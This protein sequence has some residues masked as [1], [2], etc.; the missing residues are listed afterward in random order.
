M[1]MMVALEQDEMRSS[2]TATA[3]ASR[4]PAIKG[5][6]KTTA[7]TESPTTTKT[8][9]GVTMNDLSTAASPDT[10]RRGMLKKQLSFE[11]DDPRQGPPPSTPETQRPRPQRPDPA[12]ASATS[13]SV[14]GVDPDVQDSAAVRSSR[15]K[16][17]AV[18]R[19]LMLRDRHSVD[20]ETMTSFPGHDRP[21]YDGR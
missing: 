4:S 5:I 7:T 12:S 21:S 19:R 18:A 20:D 14:D 8:Q 15:I 17:K 2:T 16:N 10:K 1:T 11:T 9:P 13:A 3:A 6:L